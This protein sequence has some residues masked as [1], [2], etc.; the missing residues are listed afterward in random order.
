MATTYSRKVIKVYPNGVNTVYFP[1]L[2]DEE[3]A[4]RQKNL[5]DAAE[6]FLRCV[7]R[8]RYEAEKNKKCCDGGSDNSTNTDSQNQHK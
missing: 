3:R 2:T 1:D 7:E 8:A 5:Y 4:K 6:R